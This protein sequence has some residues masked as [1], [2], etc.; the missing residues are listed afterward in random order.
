MGKKK[1]GRNA[2]SVASFDLKRW[3]NMAKHCRRLL[4]LS[5]SV[6]LRLSSLARSGSSPRLTFSSGNSRHPSFD[7]TVITYIRTM[8]IA[9]TV[10]AT[11]LGLAAIS[12]VDAFFR[13]PCSQPVVVQRADPYVV[14]SVVC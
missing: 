3:Q 13:M 1:Q 7:T 9:E 10:F 5:P 4:S 8:K 2:E 11:A 6:S 14:L 12:G